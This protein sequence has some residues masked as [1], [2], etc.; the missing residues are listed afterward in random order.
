MLDNVDRIDACFIS[1]EE[2][3]EKYE[4]PYKPVV[5]TNAQIEWGAVKKWSE[6]VLDINSF[7]SKYQDL[8]LLTCDTN[9]CILNAMYK[10]V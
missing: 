1:K 6:K 4:R 8:K 2:F 3:E 5:V 7:V 9:G 10:S